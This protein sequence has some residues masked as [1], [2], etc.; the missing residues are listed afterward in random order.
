MKQVEVQERFDALAYD[1]LIYLEHHS[2]PGY[3]PPYT[4]RTTLMPDMSQTLMKA[5]ADVR[6]SCSRN[7]ERVNSAHRDWLFNLKPLKE[8]ADDPAHTYRR[9]LGKLFGHWLHGSV[10]G[11][12]LRVVSVNVD[13]GGT[14]EVYSMEGFSK[15]SPDETRQLVEA[16]LLFWAVLQVS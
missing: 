16:C 3:E 13:P 5:F 8:P 14:L 4:A 15:F 2:K 9:E 1:F 6:R 11:W 10:S 7:C 12:A